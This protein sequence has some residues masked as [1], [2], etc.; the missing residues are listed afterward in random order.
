MTGKKVEAQKNRIL[1]LIAEIHACSFLRWWSCLRD[2]P[3]NPSL[4]ISEGYDLR[5]GSNSISGLIE[6][7]IMHNF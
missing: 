3:L 2:L 7:L 6:S 1:V 5:R 4:L